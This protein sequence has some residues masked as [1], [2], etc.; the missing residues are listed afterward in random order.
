M[1]YFISDPHFGHNNII[2]FERIQFLTIQE[3]DNFLIHKFEEWA[4]KL[5]KDDELWVLGD[6]GNTDYLYIMYLFDCETHFMFGNHDS[7]EDI[8][9]FRDC[10]N[11]VH[12]YPLYI[13]NRIVVSHIPVAV[14]GDQVNVHGHLHNCNLDSDN[15]INC[16]VDCA[17][18]QL[19]SEKYVAG[20]CG[21]LPKYNR[22]FLWEPFADLYKFFNKR[23][24]SDIVI[25]KDGRIDL[26]ASRA[27]R[28][29][30]QNNK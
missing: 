28:K 22:R 23:D 18:Y 1:K 27:L 6:W 4:K 14:Y 20:R 13:T 8:Q 17:N 19:V 12:E 10:F 2:K 7:T 11:Y 30:S 15:Y 9:K 26:A 21:K 16:S 25:D 29:I 24:N 5:K 3:H